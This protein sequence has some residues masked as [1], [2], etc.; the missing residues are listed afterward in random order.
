METSASGM[1]IYF[2]NGKYASRHSPH[3]WNF[4]IR[5]ITGICL[6]RHILGYFSLIAKINEYLGEWNIG[7]GNAHILSWMEAFPGIPKREITEDMPN[8]AMREI[9][10]GYAW[11]HILGIPNFTL[12]AK[13]KVCLTYLGEWKHRL[14]GMLIYFPEWKVCSIPNLTIDFAMREITEDM[15][16]KA[17]P[18]LFTYYKNQQNIWRMETS[19]SGMLIYF[20]N[21]KYMSIPEASPLTLQCV[22]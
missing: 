18:R 10:E 6:W 12:I 1:L 11:R 2:L 4:A 13:V 3:R 22:K 14:P 17:Y 7:F 21:G 5:E 8:F 19:A 16:M 20:L 15:P 9:T